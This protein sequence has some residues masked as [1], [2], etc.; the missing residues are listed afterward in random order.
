ML[1]ML[2]KSDLPTF[3]LPC[4]VIGW[5]LWNWSACP[6]SWWVEIC[7]WRNC[8]INLFGFLVAEW[9]FW[10]SS[11]YLLLQQ[12]TN[13]LVLQNFHP[14]P[15]SCIFTISWISDLICVTL[16]ATLRVTLILPFMYGAWPTITTEVHVYDLSDCIPC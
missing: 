12:N 8:Y 2:V 5:I 7:I 11:T 16:V 15:L 1:S 10:I 3:V 4:P 9:T 6:T 14:D 13:N